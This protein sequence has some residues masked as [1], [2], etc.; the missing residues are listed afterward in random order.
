MAGLDSIKGATNITEEMS[1]IIG[2]DSP[3][4]G[5]IKAQ[6]ELHRKLN[7][8]REIFASN[9][10]M[11]AIIRSY[12]LTGAFAISQAMNKQI[13]AMMPSSAMT[14]VQAIMKQHNSLFSSTRDIM[15]MIQPHPA[16]SQINSMQIAM[17]HISGRIAALA[18]AQQDWSL[19]DEFEDISEQAI[20]LTENISG[21]V[22]MTAEK[23]VAFE[24][25]IDFVVDFIKKNR[26][27]GIY[28]LLFIDMVLRVTSFHQYFDFLKT[29]PELASKEDMRKFEVKLIKSIEEKLKAE[30]EYRV[31]NRRCKVFLK[32]NAK[33]MV[34]QSLSADF[35]VVVLQISHKWVYISYIDPND[36]I[37]QTGWL[38]KKYTDKP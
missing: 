33:S 23:T 38:M 1:R 22:A 3:M 9:N 2:F 20:A 17:S 12:E 24:T 37:S 35:D 18:A 5:I 30:K 16:F 10:A 28:S 8:F 21:G 15:K 19:I 26:K 13:A 14:A 11:Q 29:K 36:H 6:R 4:Y 27:F 25:L 32:P 7:P 31:T 34:L